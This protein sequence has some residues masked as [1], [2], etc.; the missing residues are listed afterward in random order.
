MY[1]G[2]IVTSVVEVAFV[3]DAT[4]LACDDTAA[5]QG[6][7]VADASGVLR[8]AV[9]VEVVDQGD[10]YVEVGVLVGVERHGEGHRAGIEGWREATIACH[11][12]GFHRGSELV[13]GTE[14][15][16]ALGDDREGHGK[17]CRE[18]K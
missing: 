5:V 15:L 1:G 16:A 8:G 7:A 14:R 11:L 12:P 13:V 4:H 9:S 10:G 6:P 17:E 18:E 2:R 3:W